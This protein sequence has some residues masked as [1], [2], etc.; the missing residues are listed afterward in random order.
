[1]APARRATSSSVLT[2]LVLSWLPTR[3]SLML[4]LDFGFCALLQWFTGATVTKLTPK[5]NDVEYDVHESDCGA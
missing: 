2:S 3:A 5:N 1:M 4:G